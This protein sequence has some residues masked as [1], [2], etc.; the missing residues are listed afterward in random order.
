[1]GVL[2]IRKIKDIR[3]YT[4]FRINSLSVKKTSDPSVIKTFVGEKIENHSAVD[5]ITDKIQ[6]DI[7]H[8]KKLAH[9]KIQLDEETGYGEINL[10]YS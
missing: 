2:G 5:W 3:C 7:F 4:A 10:S 6:L 8:N 1:M 9:T